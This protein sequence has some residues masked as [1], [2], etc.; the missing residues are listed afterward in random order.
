MISSSVDK[1]PPRP[2]SAGD[3]LGADDLIRDA[4]ALWRE[5][6]G[7][8]HEQMELAS[9]ETRQAGKSL[10]RLLI[11]AVLL[12]VF[13][14]GAWLGLLGASVVWLHEQGLPVSLAL[15]AGV[16]LNL[17]GALLIYGM[18]GYHSRRLQFSATRRSLQALST[19]LRGS[20]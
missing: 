13:L 10:V 11:F 17:L 4:G 7:L 16:G 3:G 1:S 12:A 15:A 6:T 19:Q 14:L 20:R 2:A 18:I 8:A 5:L 9:L